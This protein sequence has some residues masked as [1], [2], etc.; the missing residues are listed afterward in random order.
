MPVFGHI[1]GAIQIH[2]SYLEAGLNREKYYPNYNHPG[3]ANIMKGRTLTYALEHLGIRPDSTVIVY[4]SDPDGVMAAARLVWGLM[5]AGVKRVRLL[6]GG[7]DAWTSHGQSPVMSIRNIWD[8]TP[9]AHDPLEWSIRKEFLIESEEVRNH[10]ADPQ[11]SPAGKLI[12]F[13]TDGE[14]NGS[15]PQKYTFFARAGHIPKAI[16]QGDWDNLL[17]GTSKRLAGHL[18]VVAKRWRD[19]GIIDPSVEDGSTPLTFHCGTGWRSS[20][21]FLVGYLLGFRS[22]NYEE[23]FL[24]WSHYEE[25]LVMRPNCL[26]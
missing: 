17:D 24:G 12:D 9:P 2:P 3:E 16:H 5:Y 1:P 8:L 10:I 6:D 14:W 15:T 11:N 22:K 4:G 19:Q 18:D 21:A 13:R 26:D 20:I 25:H 23:G 7:I